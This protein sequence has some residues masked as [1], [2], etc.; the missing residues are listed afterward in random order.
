MKILDRLPVYT[1]WF[2]EVLTPNSGSVSIR[3]WPDLSFR[4]ILEYQGTDVYEIHDYQDISTLGFFPDEQEILIG[5]AK[6][7]LTDMV[8]Y[9]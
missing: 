1:E 3:I 9:V 5:L 7:I 6:R 4:I 2:N 8:N